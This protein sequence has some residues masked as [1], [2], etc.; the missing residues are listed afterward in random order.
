MIRLF[1]ELLGHYRFGC[2]EAETSSALQEDYGPEAYPSL[3]ISLAA[4]CAPSGFCCS[5][6]GQTTHVFKQGMRSEIRQ[7]A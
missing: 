1:A 3:S 5:A 2:F 6:P 7:S 4:L